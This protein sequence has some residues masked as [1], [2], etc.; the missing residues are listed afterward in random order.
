ML[1]SGKKKEA[2][3]QASL[4]ACKILDRLVSG[5]FLQN[6]DS[7]DIDLDIVVSPGDFLS[8]SGVSTWDGRQGERPEK[9]SGMYPKNDPISPE[10]FIFFISCQ[11]VSLF[12]TYSSVILSVS[13]KQG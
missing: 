3:V 11:Q 10:I 4:E 7:G 2:V 13:F 5:I 1:C 8:A 9:A 6:F 12:S